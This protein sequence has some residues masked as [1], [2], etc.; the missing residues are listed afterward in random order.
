MS[1]QDDI[2]QD[3]LERYRRASTTDGA[4][5]SEVTR[6]AILE[7]ARR[8]AAE[9]SRASSFDT[10]RPAAN[11]PRWRI[12]AGTLGVAMLGVL[13]M[14]PR[15]STQP[16]RVSSL[17]LDKVTS[18]SQNK[19]ASTNSPA[20]APASVSVPAEAPPP[21]PAQEPVPSPKAEALRKARDQA[22]QVVSNSSAYREK[23]Q[24]SSDSA[25]QE[26]AVTGQREGESYSRRAAAPAAALPA[27]AAPTDSA[28][29]TTSKQALARTDSLQ[30][31]AGQ[32]PASPLVE[33]VHAGD[34]T[35]VEALLAEG[36]DTSITD[37]VG[38]TPLMLAVMANR[39]DLVSELLAHGADPNRADLSGAT[40][41][42][43][44]R[45]LRND[46]IAALLT[47]AGAR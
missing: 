26:V 29:S 8:L 41:L 14:V 12:A 40:P 21:P 2:D 33:A 31:L 25:L 18:P 39:K 13:L 15:Y 1:E 32:A 27:P 11:W 23:K 4:R 6:S 22:P 44:A 43:K 20:S 37:P 38:R 46:E 7:N 42:Q 35:K 28:T 9:N 16:D 36:A 47:S 3:L 24:G 17:S 5:P 19:L 34:A 45:A 10:Q 30:A